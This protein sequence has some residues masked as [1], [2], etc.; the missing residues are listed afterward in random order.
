MT[1]SKDSTGTTE[2]GID[3][4]V[5]SMSHSFDLDMEYA[6][7]VNCLKKSSVVP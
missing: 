5:R 3:I 6:L 7:E 4:S 1:K 2:V